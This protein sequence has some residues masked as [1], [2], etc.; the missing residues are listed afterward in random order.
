[1]ESKIENKEDNSNKNKKNYTPPKLTHHG[2]VTE[3]TKGSSGPM[4]D[5][6]THNI[7]LPH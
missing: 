6:A 3:L 2:K 4:A 5:A 1:M 7:S